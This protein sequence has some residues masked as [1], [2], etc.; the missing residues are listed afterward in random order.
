[1]L[2][3][4]IG[5]F[6]SRVSAT[7]GKPFFCT[8]ASTLSLPTI[9]STS[10]SSIASSVTASD[11]IETSRTGSQPIRWAISLLY[12]SKMNP[13]WGRNFEALDPVEWLARMRDHIVRPRTAPDAVLRRVRQPRQGRAPAARARPGHGSSGAT[14]RRCSPSWAR[15]IVER[16]PRLRL[17]LQRAPRGG[18]NPPR[19]DKE[20]LRRG[21]RR[22]TRWIHSSAPAAASA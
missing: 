11:M 13:F 10:P 14:P 21:K 2:F 3:P 4:A 17:G 19:G 5:A 18:V 20:S 8:R 6:H 9:A 15:L 12:R 1:M 22:S 16:R 7:T